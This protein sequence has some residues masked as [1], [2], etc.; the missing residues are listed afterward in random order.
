MDTIRF[1]LMAWLVVIT[2]FSVLHTQTIRAGVGKANITNTEP[3]TIVNDS[4]YVKAL[5][6]EDNQK[7]MAI[8]TIDVVALEKIGH[9]PDHYLQSVRTLLQEKFN[10]QPRYVLIN[11]SHCHGVP[12]TD[13]VAKTV[14]AVEKALKDLEPV[15]MGLNRG[16]EDRISINRRLKLADGKER[17]IRHAYSL[18]P[19]EEIEGVGVIDPEV[20][21][22]CLRT[23]EGKMKA[24]MY[25]YACHPIQ[26]VPSKGDRGNSAGFPGYASDLIEKVYNN[27]SMAF[28]IQGCAG[29]VNPVLYKNVATPRSAEIHG[30]MLGSTILK[31]I[32]Q[33][34]YHNIETLEYIHETIQLPLADLSGTIDSLEIRKSELVNSINGTSLNFK[35]FLTL[36]LKYH[37][38]QQYPSFYAHQ[39]FHE[40]MLGQ[41][42]FLLLDQENKKLIADYLQNIY[43]MEELTVVKENLNL[44]SNHQKSY[45]ASE[46]KLLHAEVNA[47]K[48]GDF[49]LITFPG[50]LSTQI[51]LN[52]KE[53]SPYDFTYVSA[54]T[55]G[56][57]YYAP[58]DEQLKNRGGAQEDSECVLGMGWQKIFEDK[59][60]DIINKL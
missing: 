41:E 32:S 22:M 8:I 36:Y 47:L 18:P 52:I 45:L 60:L 25:N 59:A 53:K 48:M 46:D 34:D 6:L 37:L 13:V 7:T 50:E 1:L 44:L 14:N 35:T 56:Y 12:G 28:F 5:V 55:N 40:K 11:A 24:V 39:Y 57:N 20:G 30:I 3:G 9:I 4:L 15:Q 31:Q 38:F 51:G 19:D 27:G 2:Q 42:N 54:Y 29:D 26:G 21:I 58:T 23:P 10:I 33:L 43:H 16:I 49:V 17:D